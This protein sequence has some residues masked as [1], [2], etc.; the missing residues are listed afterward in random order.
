[1]H[2][3]HVAIADAAVTPGAKRHRLRP[4]QFD[5]G[6]DHL[7]RDA[8]R[9]LRPG[10]AD[11]GLRAQLDGRLAAVSH[12][13]PVLR[14]DVLRGRG[15]GAW[16]RVRP[17]VQRLDG[18]GVVRSVPWLQH[19]ALPDPAVGVSNSR[20]R[21]RSAT[22]SVVCARS[23]SASCRT[24]SA[25][26]RFTPATGTRCG[27]SATTG[28]SRC[29]CT[30]GRRRRCRCSHRTR[31]RAPVRRSAST[32]RWHRLAIGSTRPASSRSRSSRSPTARGR[33]AGSRTRSSER[34]RCGSSTTPGSTRKVCCPSRRP[35]TTTAGCSAASRPIA[36]GCATSTRSGDDNI[37]FETDYPH[38]DT[39]WPHSKEYCEKILTGATTEQSY[40]V[41]RGNAIRMLELDRV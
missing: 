39:T 38:T 25:C 36:T 9:L 31:R 32:T 29:A 18:R 37:C 26:R 12:V 22:P 28:V 3:R 14:P 20:R 15:Q 10:G 30:S 17:G 4:H 40:D 27:L 24:T 5:D 7:R 33:S 19:P 23:A 16:A 35:P 21:R 2:K 1:M 34:T 11:Q 41:L 8:P 6:A 13:P